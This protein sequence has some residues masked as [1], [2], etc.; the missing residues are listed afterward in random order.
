M[1]TL[2]TEKHP[3][4][5]HPFTDGLRESRPNG[6]SLLPA[7]KTLMVERY[8]MEAQFFIEELNEAAGS[9]P[10]YA[11]SLNEG[12]RT[13]KEKRVSIMLVNLDEQGGKARPVAERIRAEARNAHMKCPHLIFLSA[14]ELP[15]EDVREIY[16]LQYAWLRREWWPAIFQE[17]SRALCIREPRKW[18][19]T[20]RF[21]H[22]Q[23]HY[24]LYHCD[25]LASAHICVGFQPA[26]QAVV[27]A[28][29]R[30]AYTVEEIADILGV[31]R[32]TVKK[33]MWE[34]R[35]GDLLAQQQLQIVEP[36]RNVF[37]TERRPGGTVIG[38]RANVIWD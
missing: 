38:I 7:P 28:G 32:P 10:Y 3:S 35:E 23:G 13:M 24:A 33:Y 25:D 14:R 21:E 26:K 34:L 9:S 30:I 15:I 17:V 20:I 12:L 4:A 2:L 8:S 6:C 5:H 29:G 22:Y 36:D 16:K 18:N 11:Q 37:W 31:T 27:L 19:S 1:R